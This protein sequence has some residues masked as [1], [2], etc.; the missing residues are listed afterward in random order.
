MGWILFLMA[1][2][3]CRLIFHLKN[4]QQEG[5][6][7]RIIAAVL[8]MALFLGGTQK[9]AAQLVNLQHAAY[10]D[11]GG[12][13]GFYSLNY[14]LTA[15][16]FNNFKLGA[17]IGLGVL[18]EGYE[19]AS[20]DLHVPITI[21]ALYAFAEKHHIEFGIGTQIASYE[22]RQINSPTDIGWT[23]KT[24]ALGSFSIGYRFQP[25]KGFLFRAF[26]SPLFYQDGI[27][28]RFEQ[29]G[30]ISLG[31]AFGKGQ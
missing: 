10:V 20:F 26:Y 4:R 13:G 18:T 15:L 14:D 21:N 29:W 12:V 3:T 30:G 11:L 25:I 6:I 16:H 17:R 22:I 1:F 7:S 31:Y 2:L 28:F 19:G 27:Y 23:R 5:M 24:E 8:S 9:A